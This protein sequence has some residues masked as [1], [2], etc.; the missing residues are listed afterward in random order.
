MKNPNTAINPKFAINE[1][2]KSLTKAA[3]KKNNDPKN[4]RLIQLEIV[5]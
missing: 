5:S 2:K 1:I 3:T 4:K